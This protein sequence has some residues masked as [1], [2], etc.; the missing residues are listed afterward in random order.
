VY[1][2]LYS[3]RSM[4]ISEAERRRR[5][6]GLSTMLAQWYRRIPIPFRPEHVAAAVGDSELI[7]V[8]KLYHAYLLALVHVHGIYSNQAEWVSRVSS[9][10]REAIR[11]YATSVKGT[12]PPCETEAREH[13]VAEGWNHCVEVSRGCIKLF[14]EAIPTECLL[15]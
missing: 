2:L 12:S 9:L 4:R 11:N 10:S 7:Q 3:N 6:E 8:V 5:V 1:E 13:P 14:Q 15:W